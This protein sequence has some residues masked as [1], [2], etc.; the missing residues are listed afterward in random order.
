MFFDFKQILKAKNMLRNCRVK[1]KTKFKVNIIPTREI[2]VPGL[3]DS[4]STKSQTYFL[5]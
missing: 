4:R 1:T 5:D 3:C 2:Y